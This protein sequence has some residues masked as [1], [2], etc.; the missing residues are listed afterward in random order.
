MAGNTVTLTFAGDSKSLERTF[1]RVGSGAKTMGDKV[2]TAGT[3]A[4]EAAGGLERLGDGADTGEQRII[5][6]RDAITGTGDVMQ[7]FKDGNIVQLLTGFADIGSSIANFVA[8][9]LKTMATRIG[10]L[11]T[12]TAAEATATSGAAAAQTSLNLAFLASPIGLTIAAIVA[13]GAAFVIAWKNS[14]TFR[15]VVKGAFNAVLGAITAL[16]TAVVTAVTVMGDVFMGVGKA[17]A[18]PYIEAFKLIKKLWNSTLGG[19]GFEFGGWDPPGPGSIPGIKFKIPSMHT[20]G[21]VPGPVGAEVPILAM[22]GETVTP[23]GRAPTAGPVSVKVYIDGREIHQA[24][25]RL[26]RTSGPLGLA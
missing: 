24:L 26:Q 18:T 8:P 7:G 15:D 19:F 14:E 3:R 9:A 1:D 10:I 5:G 11:T 17:L 21:V 16:K 22:A 20:G 13:L 23:A 2:S 12:A 25:L 6:F 4:R